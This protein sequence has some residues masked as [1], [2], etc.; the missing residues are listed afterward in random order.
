MFTLDC[1]DD[2]ILQVTDKMNVNANN[3]RRIL[4]I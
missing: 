2:L 4:D 1:M 3:K